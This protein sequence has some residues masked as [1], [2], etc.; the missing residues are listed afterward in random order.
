VFTL[1][2]NMQLNGGRGEQEI[3]SGVLYSR[4]AS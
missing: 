2:Q 1:G 4:T 3:Q